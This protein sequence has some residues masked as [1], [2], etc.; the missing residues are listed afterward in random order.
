M[1]GMPFVTMPKFPDAST[2]IDSISKWSDITK[3]VELTP[4]TSIGLIWG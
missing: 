4:F 3:G 1:I 2:L